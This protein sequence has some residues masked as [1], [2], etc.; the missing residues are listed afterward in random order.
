M[1]YFAAHFRM[2]T[3]H[4]NENA[5]EELKRFICEHEL[6]HAIFHAKVNRPFL[7]VH[8]LYSVEKIEGLTNMFTVELLLHDRYIKDNPS[9]SMYDSANSRGVPMQFIKLKGM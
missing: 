5:R 6:G 2:K 1:R 8:T 4:L 7:S 9:C 3:I